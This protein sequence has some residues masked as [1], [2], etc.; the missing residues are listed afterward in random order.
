[1]VGRPGSSPPVRKNVIAGRVVHR[2][3]VHALD[4]AEVVGDAGRVRQEVR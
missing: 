3:G 1:M 4:E 2:L